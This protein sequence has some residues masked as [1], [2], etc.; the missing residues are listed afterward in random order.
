MCFPFRQ[1][2]KYP[3]PEGRFLNCVIAV[4]SVILRET[5]L[6]ISVSTGE[7]VSMKSDI[8]RVVSFTAMEILEIT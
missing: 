7:P 6:T 5:T 3:D 2:L 8:L 4:I 1:V